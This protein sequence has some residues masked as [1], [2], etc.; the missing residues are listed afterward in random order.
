[1]MRIV[2]LCIISYLVPN[3]WGECILEIPD[4][5]E[6]APS[7]EKNIGDDWF[8][9]PYITNRL[10]VQ[11]GETVNGYCATGFEDIVFS[12]EVERDCGY[13]DHECKRNPVQ[14]EWR[15]V[16][17][18]DR[19]IAIECSGNSLKCGSHV[20]T[21]LST[22][23]CNNVKWAVQSAQSNETK[24]SWCQEELHVFKLSTNNLDRNRVLAHICYDLGEFS[25]QAVKYNTIKRIAKAWSASKLLP[26]TLN[27]LPETTT[28]SS[29]VRFLNTTLLHIKNDDLQNY[30]ET[31]S[32]KNP[33][34]QLTRYEYA[35]IIQSGPFVNYF[36]QYHQLLDI[37]WWKNLRVAN[38]RHFMN[39]LEQ[40][41]TIYSYMI[42]TGT[43]DVVQIP[44]WSNPGEF[45]YLEVQNG[46]V[47]NTLPQY[48][49]T[50]LESSDGKNPDLYVFGYNSPY[51][52]FFPISKV[53]FCT[54]IC[55]DFDWLKTVRSS[56]HYNNFGIVFCCSPE[57]VKM[58]AYGAKLPH[59]LPTPPLEIAH[60]PDNISTEEEQEEPLPKSEEIAGSTETPEVAENSEKQ[61]KPYTI[62]RH[63][64]AD[65][66]EDRSVD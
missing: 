57:S 42:Y 14:T 55:S 20:L 21:D 8:K 64:Y 16:E 37:L 50:Y 1:M 53:K 22:I 7:W 40:H 60:I 13:Y 46:F 4:N 25:L 41:T 5:K 51:A 38:W 52:E 58:S 49:W 11:D 54:D 27:D 30:F 65:S 61:K 15:E 45:E 59:R 39:A 56:F 33:W 12:V 3:A 43:L 17:V 29:E 66:V 23:K 19:T 24:T 31:L 44:V 2:I 62:E 36:N 63:I 9:I 34:L 6:N 47:N 26:V 35:N 28:L 32:K 48:I 10:K 18:A